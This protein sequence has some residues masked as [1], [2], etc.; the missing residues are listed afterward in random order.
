MTFVRLYHCA[1]FSDDDEIVSDEPILVDRFGPAD[2]QCAR[3]KDVLLRC[4][5]QIDHSA[6]HCT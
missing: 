5:G 6:R 2:P 1:D 4:D 3:L